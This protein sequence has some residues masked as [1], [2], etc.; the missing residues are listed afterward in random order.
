MAFELAL[1]D[2]YI[3]KGA[4]ASQQ[5]VQCI[6]DTETEIKASV[7]PEV[8]PFGWTVGFTKAETWK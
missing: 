1:K 6:N 7:I 2:R 3:K 5:C 4:K 8:I